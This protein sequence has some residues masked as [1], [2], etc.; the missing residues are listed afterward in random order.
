MSNG[1]HK[2]GSNGHGHSNGKAAP[3]VHGAAAPLS[4]APFFAMSRSETAALY[5]AISHATFPD[6]EVRALVSRMGKSLEGP[7]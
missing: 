4:S 6:A 2:N 3:P 5:R 1:N 7:R